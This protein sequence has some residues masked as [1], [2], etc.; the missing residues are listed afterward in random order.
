VLACRLLGHRYRFRASG[1]VMTWDCARC[2]VAGGSKTYATA[3]EAER[4]AAAFDREDR[5]EV[6]RRAP[7]VA[8]LPLRLWRALRDRRA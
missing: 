5:S 4:F 2:G 1:A 6:G 7:L 8:L 3:A